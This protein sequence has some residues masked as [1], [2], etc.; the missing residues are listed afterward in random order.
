MLESSDATGTA[1]GDYQLMR[2]GRLK[3]AYFASDSIILNS[4]TLMTSG[5]GGIIP[6]GLII[7]TV[8]SVTLDASGLT[9]YAVI[10]PQAE[11]ASLTQVFIIKSFEF[12]E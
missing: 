7:G 11:L 6:S 10:K 8:E 9:S 1:I 5:S 12:V 2:Q 4:D 3:L